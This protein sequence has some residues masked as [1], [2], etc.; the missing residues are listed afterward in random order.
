MM[1]AVLTEGEHGFL[2]E[3]SFCALGLGVTGYQADGAS[4]AGGPSLGCSVQLGTLH[5]TSRPHT[6]PWH[7]LSHH[8]HLL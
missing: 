5:R 2:Q 6:C 8:R 7:P 3:C 1:A 4:K